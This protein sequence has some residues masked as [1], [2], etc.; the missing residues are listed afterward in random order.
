MT[1]IYETLFGWMP[2]LIQV[3]ILGLLAFLVIRLVLF[4]VKIIL[5]ALPFV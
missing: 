3:A 4:I 5:D 1:A 2:T